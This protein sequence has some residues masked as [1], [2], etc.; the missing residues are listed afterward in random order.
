MLRCAARDGGAREVDW[1]SGAH[2]GD[3]RARLQLVQDQAGSLCSAV[4]AAGLEVLGQAAVVIVVEM[5]QEEMLDAGRL[6]SFGEVVNHEF[7]ARNT[8]AEWDPG[9]R[10]RRRLIRQPL[11]KK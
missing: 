1:S 10:G 3:V 7:A 2:G 4:D 11:V 8:L 9:E 5:S 6:G